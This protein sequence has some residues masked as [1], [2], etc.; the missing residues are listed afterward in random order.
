MNL[1]RGVALLALISLPA[2]SWI[3][4]RGPATVRSP[5]ATLL[6]RSWKNLQSNTRGGTLFEGRI[7][8]SPDASVVYLPAQAERGAR[9]PLVV[10]VPDRAFGAVRSALRLS[11]VKIS[12]R[13]SSDG[14]A[15]PF[16]LVIPGSTVTIRDAIRFAD[17]TL[18]VLPTAHT[19]VLAGIGSGSRA[20]LSAGLAD[21]SLAG[22]LLLLGA[23]DARRS[24]HQLRLN[25]TNLQALRRNKTRIVLAVA[26]GARVATSEARALARVFHAHHIRHRL[27][28][29]SGSPGIDLWQTELF[30]ALAYALTPERARAGASPS[31]RALPR[32]WAFILAGPAGG[33]VWQGVIPNSADPHA[34]RFSLVYLPPSF[35]AATRYPVLYLLH[36][37]RG[38]PFGFISSLRFAATADTLIAQRRA[39]PFI[40]VMPPAGDTVSYRGEWTGTWERYVVR[41]V[42]PFVDA[43]LPT[44]PMGTERAIA[45]FSAGGYGAVN[46]GFR[47]PGMF[48]TLEAWS[49]YFTAPHDGS[50]AHATKSQLAAN[51]P[52]LTISQVAPALRAS[53]TRIYLSSGLQDHEALEPTRR[54]SEL[55]TTFN[56]AHET[57][58]TRGDHRGAF[59]RSMLADAVIYAF[60]SGANVSAAPTGRSARS[61]IG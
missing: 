6:P 61:P 33:S 10:L 53:H 16:V 43:R 9:L 4:T 46:I 22:A 50:L 52:T 30:S 34:K 2:F 12:D 13:L 44:S 17:D 38:S 57:H 59:W 28:T 25:A 49:G 42:V 24:G 56:L 51:D 41:D 1:R 40:A 21:P 8:R 18:P 54:F 47:Y 58:I 31:S 37:I 35:N 32:S 48:G 15:P 11:V 39:R 19:R 29:R 36:G 3:L 45:G 60:G 26:T 20:A 23:N 27:T 7:G 14:S 55:L 5:V